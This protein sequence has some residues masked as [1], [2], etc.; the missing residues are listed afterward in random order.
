MNKVTFRE[1]IETWAQDSPKLYQFRRGLEE[2]QKLSE[3]S[4][5]DERGYQWC[6][7]VHG[8][9]GGAPFCEHG[10]LNFVTWHRPYLLDFEIKMRDQIAKIA[11]QQAAEEWRVPYW[12]WASR[13]TK[14]IPKAFTDKTYKDGRKTK[15]NPLY[16][17]PYQLPFP[18]GSPVPSPW[19]IPT[20]R[21]AGTVT[22]LKRLRVGVLDAL[23]KKQFAVANGFSRSIEQPHNGLHVWV[24]GYMVTLRSSFDP[25]FWCH[26]ANV[27][28][29]WWIWQQKH[30]NSTIPGAQR[31][32]TCRPFQFQ[33]NRAEAFFDTRDLG[34]EYTGFALNVEHGAAI[35]MVAAG[36]KKKQPDTLSIDIGSLSRDFDEAQLHILGLRHTE[37][38]YEIRVFVNKKSANAKT[39]QTAASGYLGTVTILGHGQCPGATGHCDLRTEPQFS[40]DVR[41]PHHLA[42]FDAYLDITKGLQKLAKAQKKKNSGTDNICLVL[43]V[44]GMDGKQRPNS[45]I[46]FDSVSV[47]AD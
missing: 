12:N 30:G 47:S 40:G 17:M 45:V 10:T 46:K 39:S 16:S 31:N 23:E 2:M 11:D 33:D 3:Q 9:F 42:P 29:Q 25:I 36:A 18:P 21:D 35:E 13:T 26:H 28:R 5:M 41:A 7:G 4:L 14:G 44:I 8:G 20:Y 27:D 43:V 32:F 22:D 34:Y 19:P 15:P 24:L 6:A 37:E 38:T 1:N